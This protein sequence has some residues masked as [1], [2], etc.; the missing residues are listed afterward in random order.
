[1]KV[2][3]FWT[4]YLYLILI[5]FTGCGGGDDD[6]VNPT[7]SPTPTPKPEVVEPDIK[8]PAQI[9]TSGMTFSESKPGSQSV[10]FTCNSDWTLS[11][12]EGRSETSWCKPSATSG[13]KGYATITFTVTENPTYEDRSVIVTITAG[14]SSISFTISQKGQK[15]LLVS[16]DSYELDYKKNT[17]EI[18]VKSNIEYQ[19]VIAE[20]AKTWIS[21]QTSRGLTTFKHT[22]IIQKNEGANKRIGEIYFKSNLKKYTIKIHQASEPK[23]LVNTENNITNWGNTNGTNENAKEE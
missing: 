8:L 17:I 10:S 20:S 12:K 16:K 15:A 18:E 3:H 19:V 13:T 1:M 7:P 9:T 22:F 2:S 11:I 6:P 5:C 23:Y 4:Y 21:E 14:S